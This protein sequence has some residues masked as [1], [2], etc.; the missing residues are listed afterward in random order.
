MIVFFHISI[1]ILILIVVYDIFIRVDTLITL[2]NK[3]IMHWSRY[4]YNS[5]NIE[6]L[7][8]LS[9][10]NK[11]LRRQISLIA[12]KNRLFFTFFWFF[13]NIYKNIERGFYMKFGI[14]KSSIKKV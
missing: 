2:N 13:G 6:S 12:H 14:R 11:S 9:V 4:E 10:L 3:K 8:N 7:L 5:G 1:Y